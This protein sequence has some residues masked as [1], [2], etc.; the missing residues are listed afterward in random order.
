MLRKTSAVG[1]GRKLRRPLLT[2][3]Q[4]EEQIR[5]NELKRAIHEAQVEEGRKVR[6]NRA[7]ESIRRAEE[8]W[9]G[10]G[11]SVRNPGAIA[12]RA[13]RSGSVHSVPD[14][15]G[16]WRGI[17]GIA[18][19]IPGAL[20]GL[21]T[22]VEVIG[23]AIVNREAE[24][25]LERRARQR[26]G[27]GGRATNRTGAAAAA[28]FHPVGT[29]R[30]NRRGALAQPIPGTAP[31]IPGKPAHKSG[32]TAAARSAGKLSTGR[33]PLAT[34]GTS[35]Q[36]ASRAPS[37]AA[38]PAPARVSWRVQNLGDMLLQSL[39]P[40]S[41]PRAAARGVSLVQPTPQAV[42]QPTPLTAVNS[43]MIGF[44][45]PSTPTDRCNCEP[46]RKKRKSSSCRNPVVSRTTHGDIRTT[47]VRL[48][49]PPSKQK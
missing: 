39:L 33:N 44:V 49:C 16:S 36:T 22:S 21:Q 5:G 45:P 31:V 38:L 46:Q 2:S 35:S 41:A 26:I 8:I 1:R 19:N 6:A 34:R 7:A 48:V 24:R 18:G 29:S 25:L 10:R 9:K 11:E 4:I 20:G 27:A 47:K 17:P 13:S 28:V 12:E 14:V 30:T 43:G 32:A 42:P 23:G 3:A 37:R 15:A 40:R